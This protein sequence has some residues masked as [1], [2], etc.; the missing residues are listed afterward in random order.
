MLIGLRIKK[1][2]ELLQDGF[3][4]R[5]ETL[6]AYACLV[7]MPFFRQYV[8]AY[9]ATLFMPF[10]SIWNDIPLFDADKDIH[11]CVAKYFLDHAGYIVPFE[12]VQAAPDQRHGDFLY[13]F[14][15]TLFLH[16]QQRAAKGAIGGLLKISF[17]GDQVDHAAA[18]DAVVFHALILPLTQITRMFGMQVAAQRESLIKLRNNAVLSIKIRADA[19]RQIVFF[20]TREKILSF[21]SISHNGVLPYSMLIGLRIKR[22]VDLLQDAFQKRFETMPA[23]ACLVGKSFSQQ[24]ASA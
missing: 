14:Q 6:P 10:D 18:H 24:Y 22:V 20:R 17:L 15:L 13:S 19:M 5:F 4:K 3:Q 11:I 1:V 16:A 2:V 8:S 21:F 12:L 23:Y 7:G 9:D